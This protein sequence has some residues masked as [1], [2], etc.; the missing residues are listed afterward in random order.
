MLGLAVTVAL[1]AEVVG[2]VDSRDPMTYL[3]AA[4]FVT[5]AGLAAS[6]IPT[7]KVLS[8]NPSQALRHE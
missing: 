6:L 5:V 1:P 4:L 7:R 8:L 2:A 3:L